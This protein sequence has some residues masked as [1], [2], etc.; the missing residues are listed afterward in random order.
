MTSLNINSFT[1]NGKNYR[2]DD[3]LDLSE[4]SAFLEEK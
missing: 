1:T 3:R 4:V 2:A